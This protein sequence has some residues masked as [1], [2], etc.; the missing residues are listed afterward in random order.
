M[1]RLGACV[2]MF[3]GCTVASGTGASSTEDALQLTPVTKIVKKSNELK[4]ALFKE[5][6]LIIG[7]IVP[8]DYQWVIIAVM[9]L[10]H[11]QGMFY[12][13][14]RRHNR[15]PRLSCGFSV[16]NLNYQLS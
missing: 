1:T 16:L 12:D 7:A 11:F 3:V 5:H 2:G 14:Y 10:P 6:F 4:T 9:N 15:N 13:S 8:D